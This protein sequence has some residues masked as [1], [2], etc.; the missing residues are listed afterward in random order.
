MKTICCFYVMSCCVLFAFKYHVAC[1]PFGCWLCV[2]CL[3]FTIEQHVSLY[4]MLCCGLIVMHMQRI[5]YVCRCCVVCFM[6][7]VQGFCCSCIRVLLLTCYVVCGWYLISCC[8]LCCRLCVLVF[9]VQR[10][11]NVCR[12]CLV[13]FLCV[14]G[15][16][17]KVL[18]AC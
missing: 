15:F 11:A 16:A 4:D 2:F 3:C 9:V 17:Q 14:V 1:C 6:L 5:A 18:A 7:C 13:C 12:C 8:Q 10:F